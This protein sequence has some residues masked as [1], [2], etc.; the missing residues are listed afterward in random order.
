MLLRWLVINHF[1]RNAWFNCPA[2]SQQFIN[3]Y[4]SLD[5]GAGRV[6][7]RLTVYIKVLNKTIYY[8]LLLPRNDKQYKQTTDTNEL[9][10]YISYTIFHCDIFNIILKYMREHLRALHTHTV[11]GINLLTNTTEKAEREYAPDLDSGWR[12]AIKYSL[13]RSATISMFFLLLLVAFLFCWSFM[14]EWW[15]V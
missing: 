3:C 12:W 6:M 5:R 14:V 11:C 8:D 10:F 9:S 13:I 4:F 1:E 2:D 7:P 15:H